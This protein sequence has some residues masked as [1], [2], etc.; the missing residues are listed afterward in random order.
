[1]NRRERWDIGNAMIGSGI[2]ILVV[3]AGSGCGSKKAVDPLES[4]KTFQ[5]TPLPEAPA[6]P[7]AK[8]TG[9]AIDGAKE[10]TTAAQS[11]VRIARTAVEA[12]N[13]PAAVQP[14]KQGDEQL[15]GV[16]G[17]LVDAQDLNAA[18]AVQMQ[19]LKA[20]YDMALAQREKDFL[21][22]KAECTKNEASR[23]KSIGSLKAEVAKLKD[24][25]VQGTK[26][27]LS[28]I[29][30]LLIL[31]GIGSV[32]AMFMLGFR[33]GL[34]VGVV[35][36]AMGSVC[37]AVASV[38]TQIVFWT[39]IGLGVGLLGTVGYGLWTLYRHVPPA[40]DAMNKDVA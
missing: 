7:D 24:E 2:L 5:A 40:K 23:D 4:T 36:G 39:K 9:E 12:G 32:V 18:Q 1:M 33:A 38:L 30:G 31:A 6:L 35:C 28:W 14:L 3:S 26:E 29:G 15:T 11:N 17:R 8:P 27:L 10:G 22:L 16:L 19:A 13:A 37:I 34:R 21:A 20:Y 25:A